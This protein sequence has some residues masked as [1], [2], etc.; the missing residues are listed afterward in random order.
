[1]NLK[2]I[3]LFIAIMGAN[4]SFCQEPD[5]VLIVKNNDF[6]KDLVKKTEC[7]PPIYIVPNGLVTPNYVK[8]K[9]RGQLL[10]KT[11]NQLYL[12]FSG[13]GWLY[14][15]TN[16]TPSQLVFKRIDNSENFNYNFNAFYFSHKE[17]IYNLGGYGFWK[18][19][20]SLRKFNFIDKVWDVDPL[21][22]E[23]HTPSSYTHIWFSNKESAIY[24]PYHQVINTGII[25]KPSESSLVKDCYKLNLTTNRWERLGATSSEVSSLINGTNLTMATDHGLLTNSE[26]SIYLIDFENNLVKTQ[27]NGSLVQS[28]QRLDSRFLKYYYHNKIYFTNI[29]NGNY[30]SLSFPL[31]ALTLTTYK[32]WKK[33]YTGLIAS[34]TSLLLIIMLILFWKIFRKKRK[35]KNPPEIIQFSTHAI[36]ELSETEHHLIE[37]LI[38]NCKQKKSAS[39]SEINYILG[40]KNKNAGLQKKVRSDIISSINQKYRHLT[41]AE[42]PLIQSIRNESD[43]RYFEYFIKQEMCTEAEKLISVN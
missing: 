38:Q 30:D 6:F 17:E 29:E 41:L 24:S 36:T 9:S 32:V 14:K 20:G 28:L 42:K 39:V 33:S 4:L 22:M 35:R 12:S 26:S 5:S 16:T 34:I 31:D 13:G 10:I 18:S 15:L 11:A 43:K 40:T 8:F 23:L 3:C 19:N 27:R 25:I 37:M 2:L 21:N 1:M 7:I